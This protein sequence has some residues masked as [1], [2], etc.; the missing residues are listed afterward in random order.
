MRRYDVAIVGAGPT[1]S[2][3]ALAYARRGARVIL[4]EASTRASQRLA[5][6]WL[7]PPAV[8]MLRDLGIH[9]GPKSSDGMGQGFAVFPED[10]SEPI[11]LPYP[12]GSR[13]LAC[14]HATLVAMLHEAIRL[15]SDV[16]FVIPAR[17]H[18]VED[19]RLTFSSNGVDETVT[20]ERIVGADGRDSVVRRSLG[21]ATRRSTCSQMIGVRLDDVQLPMEGY[22][23]VLCG[24]TGPI[25][26]YRLADDS[27]R[28]LAD[29]PLER[30]TREDWVRFVL[31]GHARMLPEAMRPSFVR[32]IEAKR[33]H[34]AANAVALRTTYGTRQRVLIGDAAGYYHPITAVGMT[35]GFGDALAL[36]EDEDFRV[37]TSRRVRATRAPELL[38][39]TLYEVFADL[40]VESTALRNAVYRRWRTRA[41][42]RSKTMRLLACED[43]S[44]F[45]LSFEATA[46]AVQ[47]VVRETSRSPIRLAWRRTGDLV[48][49]LA[50]RLWWLHL[51]VWRMDRARRTKGGT[52]ERIRDAMS[53][54]LVMSMA[55]GDAESP[56]ATSP[57]P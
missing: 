35:L 10:G 32:A 1:G 11:V 6:E 39:L 37:F 50:V 54:A 34:A 28:V 56:P 52:T 30:R 29:L 19:E 40:R 41:A 38:A 4:L 31:N 45:R 14:E 55:P 23:H 26:M 33:F 57:A 7:H 18:G 42:V 22:G 46:T 2:L 44:V 17:V 5:G 21:L 53:R 48:R 9:P 36:A 43:I 3:C 51:A 16:N 25:L 27:V 47:A 49:A 8:Q 20:A 12:D 24:P 15:E 13:G